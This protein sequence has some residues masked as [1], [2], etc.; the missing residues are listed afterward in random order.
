MI[1]DTTFFEK[2]EPELRA[3]REE[4][5]RIG[6]EGDII[7]KLQEFGSNFSKQMGL[8]G[9]VDLL[10]MY[11]QHTRGQNALPSLKPLSSDELDGAYA[12]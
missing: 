2:H 3:L 7:R 6:R 12:A 8:F 9:V 10:Y 4:A 11:V 5:L 1:Y